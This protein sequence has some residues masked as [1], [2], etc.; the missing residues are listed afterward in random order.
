[1]ASDAFSGGYTLKIGDGAETEAF[2]AIPELIVAPTVG[3]EKEPINASS[4][5]SVDNHDYIPAALGDGLDVDLEWNLVLGDT[6]QKA[7]RTDV[8]NGVTR[9]FQEVWVDDSIT[10]TRSF[11]ITLLGWSDSPSFTDKH[12]LRAKGKISGAITDVYS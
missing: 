9:N 3:V 8:T 1:M 5:D 6:A 7:L 10:L 4:F 12:I 11:A 2:A